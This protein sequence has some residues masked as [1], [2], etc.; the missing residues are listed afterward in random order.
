MLSC[1]NLLREIE[2]SPPNQPIERAASPPLICNVRAREACAAAAA[3]APEATPQ[4][5]EGRLGPFGQ[6]REEPAADWRD[7]A[8]LA[9]RL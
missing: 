4:P 9:V 2:R 6:G 1:T 3:A 8:I 5:R 7:P